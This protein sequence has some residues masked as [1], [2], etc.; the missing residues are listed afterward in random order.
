MDEEHGIPKPS[1]NWRNKIGGFLSGQ[2]SISNPED[3]RPQEYKHGLYTFPLF[4][5]PSFRGSF[6]RRQLEELGI[7]NRIINTSERAAQE[8]GIEKRVNSMTYVP[9]SKEEKTPIVLQ[10]GIGGE[11]KSSTSVVYWILPRHKDVVTSVREELDRVVAHEMN[12]VARMQNIKQRER[13]LLE[14]LVS[15]GLATVYEEGFGGKYQ[16]APYHKEMG[17]FDL[18]AVWEQAQKELNE[19]LNSARYGIW[20]LGEGKYPKWTGYGIGAAIV[21]AYMNVHSGQPMSEL[22]KLPSKEILQDSLY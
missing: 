1:P 19:P 20:F 4:S 21:E 5:D 6:Y 17:S 15:E 18:K 9:H 22:V 11:A 2:F 3:Y 13:T 12:H 16:A 7:R 8:L 10:T 14:A